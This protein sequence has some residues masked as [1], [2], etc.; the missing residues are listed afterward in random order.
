[1]RIRDLVFVLFLTILLLFVSCAIRA[2][3]HAE[4]TFKTRC[5]GHV[6]TWTAIT[7]K[8]KTKYTA[9]K[10]DTNKDHTLWGIEILD[11]YSG[12]KLSE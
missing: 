1:M 3:V 8:G 5:K 11:S 6:R 7:Y 2:T 10:L 4:Y 9:Q 12:T